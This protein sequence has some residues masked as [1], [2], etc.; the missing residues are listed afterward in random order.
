MRFAKPWYRPSRGCWYVTLNGTQHNLGAD[1]AVAFARYK[2]IINRRD[3]EKPVAVDSLVGVFE[4]FLDW[5]KSHR[6]DGT[7][8][9]YRDRLSWFMKFAPDDG[10]FVVTK[11][12]VN[13]LK[14]YHVQRWIDSKKCSDGHKRGCIIAV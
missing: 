13:E 14:P 2:E 12:L 1:K 5:S 7:Y 10:S 11:L 6:A 4:A 3:N 9:W 8:N